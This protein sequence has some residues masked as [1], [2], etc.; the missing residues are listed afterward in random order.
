MTQNSYQANG[1]Q[2]QPTPSSIPSPAKFAKAEFRESDYY[3]DFEEKRTSSSDL[4]GFRSVKPPTPGRTSTTFEDSYRSVTPPSVF[5]RPSSNSFPTINPTPAPSARPQVFRPTPMPATKFIETTH[6]SQ[7]PQTT[8][9]YRAVA[10]SPMH[11]SKM[12]TE[13]SNKMQINESSE[14]SQRY[15]NMEQTRKIIH[16]D[17]QEQNQRSSMPFSFSTPT[18][19]KF[20]PCDNRES[21]YESEV[22]ST[23]IR[24]LWTPTRQMN[25]I[26]YRHVEPPRSINRSTSVPRT[27]GSRILSPMEFDQGPKMPAPNVPAPQVPPPQIPVPKTMSPRMPS[28]SPKPSYQTQTLNRYS[29]KKTTKHETFKSESTKEDFTLKMGP[30]PEYGY[31]EETAANQMK[32]LSSAFRQKSYDLVDK[33]AEDAKRPVFKRAPSEGAD[34]KKPQAYRDESRISQFGKYFF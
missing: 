6:E 7:P 2:Q 4:Q 32:K 22:D 24:P 8:M 31:I 17:S 33:I 16:F 15:V 20:V 21:D 3:S 13:T 23:K 5:D 18:P 30:P 27:F 19:T 26:R 1:H 9:Y 34:P 25:D 28:H 14:T 12:A 10:G 11:L 29:N